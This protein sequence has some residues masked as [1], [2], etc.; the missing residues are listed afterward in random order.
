MALKL[1]KEKSFTLVELLVAMAI[2][3]VLV[4]LFVQM[5]DLV[6]RS[7]KLSSQMMDS[8]AKARFVFDRM[9]MDFERMPKRLDMGYVMTNAAPGNDFFRFVSRLKGPGGDRTVSLVGYKLMKDAKGYYGLYRG[10]H[11]YNWEDLGFMGLN[12]SGQPPDLLNLNPAIAIRNDDYDLLVPDLFRVTVAFQCKN[13]GKIYRDPPQFSDGTVQIT[14]IAS[15]VVGLAIMDSKT[16][17]MMTLEQVDLLASKFV[18][19]R[20]EVLPYQA[21]STNL[22]KGFPQFMEGLP[23]PV[24][25]SVH[26]YQNFYPLD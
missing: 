9:A 15:V 14:N 6:S 18:T 3:S 11:G 13:D 22:E 5:I 19:P 4:F 21:W 20:D 7:I 8:N 16:K 10:V 12:E 25:Q 26:I 2:T 24:A 23:K 17:G 1:K